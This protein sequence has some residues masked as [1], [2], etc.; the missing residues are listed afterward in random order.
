MNS[1]RV[2]RPRGAGHGRV[3][4]QRLSVAE[5]EVSGDLAG[6]GVIGIDERKW[7]RGIGEA[8]RAIGAERVVGEHPARGIDLVAGMWAEHD[9]G[10]VGRVRSA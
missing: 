8:T 4:E 5:R 9:R 1:V 10:D 2:D 6:D 7:V 3:N